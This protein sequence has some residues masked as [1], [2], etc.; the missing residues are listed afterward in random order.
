[1]MAM[2]GTTPLRTVDSIQDV[3]VSTASVWSDRVWQLDVTLPGTVRSDVALDWGFALADGSRFTDPR[4]TP[5]REAAKRFLWTLRVDP[6]AGHRRA[7]DSSLVRAF[8]HL[9]VLIRWMAGEGYRCFVDLDRDA[10]ARFL[11]IVKAR[12]GRKGQALSGATLAGYA[13]LLNTLYLQRDRLR[14]APTEDLLAADRLRLLTGRWRQRRGSLPSTPDDIAIPLVSAAIRLLGSPADDIITLRDLAHTALRD[15][16]S[17][18]LD[19]HTTDVCV[20]SALAGFI[21]STSAREER[22]WRM[23]PVTSLTAVEL[24]VS[25]LYDACF[26]VIA[27]LVGARV[28]EILGLKAGCIVKHPSADG[29]ETFSYMSGRI[30]KTADSPAGQP[31]RWVA[32]APVVRAVAVLERLS[33][34]VR[35]CAGRDELWLMPVAG[36]DGSFHVRRSANLIDRLNGPFATFINLPLHDGRPWHLSPHQGRKTFARFVGRRDRTGLHAL[37]AHFG[38]VTRV[39]T[40]ASYVGTDFELGGL[41]DAE[42]LDETR[43]ALE[44]LLT[45]TQ[46]AGKAGRTI[47]ARSRFRGRTRD[48][49]V[50]EYVDFILRETDMRLGVCDWGYCVYRR[51]SAA[52]LGGDSG[53]NPVLRTQSTCAGC[54]NFAVTQKHR[55]VWA[56]RRQRNSDLLVHPALDPESRVAAARVD[57]CDRILTELDQNQDKNG[58]SKQHAL[59]AA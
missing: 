59:D 11:A 57:E 2:A 22:P 31:H 50:K 49:D 1:M 45:A 56:A 24:L 32:P 20:R 34:P 8:Q 5:W 29:T 37:A 40:D 46:L 4:W 10:A 16:A 42:V 18:Q 23:D 13:S 9:R 52:C 41:I 35:R 43:A 55:A 27:Y 28:S 38:H 12:P 19:Q 33:E 17:R 7:R 54:A 6:P 53:P 21:F 58:S 47:A 30:Y 26:I 39:M 36:G 48:G 44:E 14:D 3:R 51:E 15:A 25:R